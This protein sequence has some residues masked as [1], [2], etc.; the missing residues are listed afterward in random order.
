MIH[1]ICIIVFKEKIK[2]KS[3]IYRSR[4]LNKVK[5]KTSNFESFLKI[6]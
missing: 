4:F 5:P 3:L 6:L 1:I 2:E